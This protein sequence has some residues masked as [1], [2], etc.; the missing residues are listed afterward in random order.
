MDY[1]RTKG[2]AALGARLRR[3]SEQIDRDA[4]RVYAS[5]GIE[6]EQ[7]WFGVLNQLAINRTMT[8]S[9]LAQTLLITRASVSQTRQSLEDAGLVISR[10]HP[11][12]ARQRNL[13]LTPKGRRLVDRLAALWQ[14]MDAAARQVDEEAG[15]VV[16][17]LDRLEVALAGKSMFARITEQL[18]NQD[19]ILLSAKQ[20][21]AS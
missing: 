8:V 5:L 10:D 2:G 7:R 14:A 9:E 16:A 4:T 20:P 6:F 11:S 17:T 12:D 15:F 3:V 19:P 1:S 13:S 18:A 21:G